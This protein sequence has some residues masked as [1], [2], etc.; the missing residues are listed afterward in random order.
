MKLDAEPVEL[1]WMTLL[2]F[3]FITDCVSNDKH[4]YHL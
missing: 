4:R 2:S 1:S 3:G